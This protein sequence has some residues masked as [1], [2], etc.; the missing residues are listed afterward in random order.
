MVRSL[1]A[2]LSDPL[3]GL[4]DMRR[5]HELDE[6]ARNQHGLLTRND[7]AELG[8]SR[9]RRRTMLDHGILERVRPQVL[10]VVGSPSTLDQQIMAAVLDRGAPAGARTAAWLHGLSGFPPPTTIELLS[11]RPVAEGSSPGLLVHSTRWLPDHDIVLVRNIP[12]T[13]VARTVLSMCALV[14]AELPWLR[15]ARAVD[16]AC[17][18]DLATDNWLWWRLERLRRSGRNGVKVMEQVLRSRA[19]GNVTESWLE[20]ATL[21]LFRRTGLPAPSCQ[22]RID[23]CGAFVARVD[24]LYAA[25]RLVIEVNG[26]RPHRTKPQFQRDAERVRGLVLEG[27]RVLPFTYDDV[28]RNPGPM[29]AA[30]REA[31]GH[32]RAA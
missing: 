24:F 2:E 28:V 19:A 13:G 1:D 23:R 7:L 27:Y 8:I 31:L 18:R 17:Q 15:V 30:I 6:R 16:D 22:Q 12:T 26:H 14:P 5:N 32:A 4:G 3:G 21:E 11:P 29:V 20:A 10:R 9:G 25:E